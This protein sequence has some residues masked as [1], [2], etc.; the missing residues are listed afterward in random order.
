MGCAQP[1][2]RLAS[3][4]VVGCPESLRTAH[5]E[6]QTGGLFICPNRQA[7]RKQRSCGACKQTRARTPESG[8][9]AA[10]EEARKASCRPAPKAQPAK[11]A[12]VAGRARRAQ[13]GTA[14]EHKGVWT[15]PGR[16]PHT[17]RRRWSPARL[18]HGLGHDRRGC[19]R[20]VDEM[21]PA[22]AGGV[23]ISLSWRPC[24][25][26]PSACCPVP[27]LASKAVR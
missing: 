14:A 8:V 23:G 4:D 25:H 1:C 17:N 6:S 26:R 3:A 2:C 20:C 22:R 13:E 5:P 16:H 27:S 15:R 11:A 12:P 21:G 7:H 19:P 10:H 9:Q 18:R 24:E